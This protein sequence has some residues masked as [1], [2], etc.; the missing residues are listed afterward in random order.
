MKGMF[1]KAS[2]HYGLSTT[3]R[4][5]LSTWVWFPL[6]NFLKSVIYLYRYRNWCDLRIYDAMIMCDVFRFEIF[7]LQKTA[8]NMCTLLFYRNIVI[9]ELG[10]IRRM[11]CFCCPNFVEHKLFSHVMVDIT[12]FLFSQSCKMHEMQVCPW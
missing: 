12:L 8:L 2:Y 1:P 7:K 3:Y 6:S 9:A 10:M 4:Q 11:F 5:K